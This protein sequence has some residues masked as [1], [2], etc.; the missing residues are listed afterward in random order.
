MT[1]ASKILIFAVLYFLLPFILNAQ[2]SNM[3]FHYLTANEGLSQ[4]RVKC[5]LRDSRENMWFGTFD[6]LNKY[7]GSQVTVYRNQDR[8]LKSISCERITDIQEDADKNIWVATEDG[9][10]LYVPAD[11][12]FVSFKNI[13]SDNSSI[14]GNYVNCIYSDKRHNVW[15]GIE[16]GK[17]GLNKWDPRSKTFTRY[18]INV[19]KNTALANAVTGIVQDKNGNIW[20]AGWDNGLFRFEPD[21]SKFTCYKDTVFNSIKTIKRLFVDNDNIIWVSTFGAGLFSFDPVSN[22]FTK[23]NSSGDGKGTSGKLI[24]NIIQEDQDNLLIAV[25]QGGINRFNKRTKLFRYINYESNH[26][27]GL[28]NNGI[29]CLY[30]DK[31]GIL[32]VGTSGGGVNIYNPKSDKFKLFKNKPGE[33]NSLS[34]DV[35]GSIYEDSKGLLWIATDGGGVSVYNPQTQ[36][37]KNYKKD[38]QDPSSLPCNVIRHIVE[39]KNH[40]YWLGT[41]DGGL[42]KFD[43]RTG[44]FRQY[45][46][47]STKPFNISGR[48]V[49]NS[50]VDHNGMIWLSM[51]EFGID[52]LD[53]DKGIV[54][55]FRPNPALQG[56][57]SHKYVNFMYEDRHLN[58][59]LCTNDG[60]DLFDSITNSFKVYRGFPSN[61][62]RSFVEDKEGYYWAGTINKGIIRFKGDGVIL[63]VYDTSNGLPSN[64]INGILEDG[65]N[66]IWVSTG[67][68]ISRIKYKTGEI[69]NYSVSDGLQ[70]RQFFLHACLKTRSGEM[71][72]GGFNGLNSFFPD[73]LKDNDY[74]P[75]V[76]INEFLI[77]NKPVPV[78]DPKS[79]LKKVIEQTNEIV[80]N[81]KQSVFSLG[82]VAINYTHPE[83]NLYAYKMEGFDEDWNYTDDSR[84]LATYTNLDAGEYTFRVKASNNDGVWNEQG[85]SLKI[86]ITPPWWKTWW[87]RGVTPVLLLSLAYTV[88]LLRVRG[89]KKHNLKLESE[90]AERTN[91]LQDANKELEAFAYSVSHDLRTPLRGIDGFSQILLDDYQEKI[92][93]QGKNYLHRVRSAS[94]RMAQLIDDMLN[95]SRVSRSEINIQEVNLSKIALEVAN[96]LRETQPEREVEFIIQEGIKTQGDDRLLRIVLEN[97]LEN[98]WKFT[99]KHPTGRI[100]FGMQPQKEVLAYFIRDN[101]AGFDMKY[102]QKLFEA[103]QRLHTTDEFL[104]T[105]VGLAT[106]Q[107]IIHRHGGKVWAEGETEKGATFYFTIAYNNM[108]I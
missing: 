67:D 102:A 53:P 17:E 70:G 9:L 85:T 69:R 13:P 105:G 20:V 54:K 65:N 103:F 10:N 55:R 14:S 19:S 5:I 73:S 95:L 35:V 74:I 41:W 58:M 25:D 40:N 49:W 21:K 26:P 36:K 7:N 83:K 63:K 61:D 48:H 82:F 90:V 42:I 39:D 68:G 96:E 29:W 1:K 78:G 93:E 106:V 34:Y 4:N 66:N 80:L 3:A 87:F 81:W 107:R 50:V 2:K 88:F 30:K 104:G 22:K 32:W 18:Q 100:E 56:V 72:F 28:N 98:A 16:N 46:P 57:L 6:G 27:E 86:I 24:Y 71:Y 33:P 8:N 11:G 62:M 91:Q 76:Y 60:L 51:T 37:F 59:W 79:P 92:D 64:L 101:G 75:P 84:R 99:S 77:F 43:H 89:I 45:W 97:L 38:N 44:K 23:Y 47:E 15:F 94:Q 12:S 108:L 52:L 31:E